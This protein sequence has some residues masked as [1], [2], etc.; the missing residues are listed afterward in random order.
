MPTAN[1]NDTQP[2]AAD[3]QEKLADRRRTERIQTPV[4]VRIRC[5]GE[6]HDADVATIIDNIGAG[7]FYVRLLRRCE[8]GAR[9]SALISFGTDAGEAQRAV[10]LAVLGR[11]L[12]LEEMPGGAY[13][14]AVKI[15]HHRFV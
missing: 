14:V 10:R 15:I 12:R 3:S 5:A 13:G 6:G 8:P 4:H 11:V 9:L 7:G 1:V 2:Q